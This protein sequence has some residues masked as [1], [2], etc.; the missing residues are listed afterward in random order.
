LARTLPILK[1]LRTAF[2]RD[3]KSF[4]SIATN[5]FFPVTLLLLQK[6]GAFLYILAGVITVFPMSTDPLR[7]IPR[8]RLDLWPLS[9]RDRWL[10]RALSPWLNPMTWMLAAGAVW[11]AR[12]RLTAGLWAAVAGLVAIG[13]AASEL[14]RPRSAGLWRF[15]PAGP[16]PLGQLMRKNLREILSTL[17]F[18]LALLLSLSCAIWR[19]FGVPLPDEA[20]VLMTCL[21]VIALASYSQSL[22][23]MD[24][25]GGLSRYR[26]LPLSGRQIL[27]AKDLPFLLVVTVLGSPLAPL[28]AVAAGLVC[29]AM[30]HSPSIDRP[31]EQLRWRFSTG[32]PL[33]FGLLQAFALAGAGAATEFTGQWVLAPCLLAWVISV[34]FY[35]AR[36]SRDL[37]TR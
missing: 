10:L 2:R 25:E 17:D 37:Q 12:G 18:Y 5:T 36:M 14:P 8:S 31:R 21:I 19:V 27:L 20:R 6:A 33:S 7:K 4:G 24:G 3:W 28:T 22:F 26:L 32:A 16:G 29:L 11:A 23:G 9:G 1:A 34:A 35:G 30:G 13:F 15:V